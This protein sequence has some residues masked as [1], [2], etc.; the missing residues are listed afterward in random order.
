MP[1]DLHTLMR[2]AGVSR[3]WLA[4]AVG[5]SESAVDGW[6]AGRADPPS[7]VLAWLQ[8]RLAD[9]PPV[10]PPYAPVPPGRRAA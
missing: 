7:E 8:R 6:L 9:P 2:A 1:A 5:R 4:R 3:P 10:L